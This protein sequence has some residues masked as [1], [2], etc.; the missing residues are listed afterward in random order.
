MGCVHDIYIVNE[1]KVVFNVTKFTTTFEPHFHAYL[2]NG[3]ELE[4]S[5][6]VYQ[7]ELF[8]HSPV[9]IHRS[10]VLGLTKY[11][12]LPHAIFAL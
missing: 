6:F 7:T 8:M 5:T 9:H 1:S 2:L 3:Q 11:I 12:I 4:D 10:Q